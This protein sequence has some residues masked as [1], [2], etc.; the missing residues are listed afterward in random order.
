MFTTTSWALLRSPTK[1][2]PRRVVPIPAA[3]GHGNVHHLLAALT[4]VMLAATLSVVPIPSGVPLVGN[5][6]ASL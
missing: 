3:A 5:L 2:S 4:V 1:Y 6:R